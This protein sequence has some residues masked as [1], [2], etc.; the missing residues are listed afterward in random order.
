MKFKFHKTNK[1]RYGSLLYHV[2]H[3]IKLGRPIL[4]RYLGVIR[5]PD[6]RD[7]RV[8]KNGRVL[9]FKTRKLAAEAL[10]K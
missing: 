6:M 8:K 9:K 5:S 2:Y 4:Y 1:S 7:F 10:C 3:D